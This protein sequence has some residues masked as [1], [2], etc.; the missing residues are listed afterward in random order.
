MQT[1]DLFQKCDLKLSKG[2]LIGINS[3]GFLIWKQNDK[4][5]KFVQQPVN[6]NDRS[7]MIS[8]FESSDL[9]KNVIY[10]QSVNYGPEYIYVVDEQKFVKIFVFR[11][12]KNSKRIMELQN[13]YYVNSKFDGN[14]KNFK[15]SNKM[16]YQKSQ[17]F[18]CQPI[19]SESE[20]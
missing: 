16:L 18:L 12:D 15:I 17:A 8:L 4:S 9:L 20:E 14:F 10:K 13:D 1:F 6:L 19:G 11:L 2:D 5:I 7:T 3:V